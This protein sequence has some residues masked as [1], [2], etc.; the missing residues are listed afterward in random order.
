SWKCSVFIDKNS[1]F[2][3]ICSIQLNFPAPTNYT[4]GSRNGES[5]FCRL[6][7]DGQS[8]SKAFAGCRASGVWLQSHASKSGIIDSSWDA[9]EGYATGS[10][11]GR[12]YHLEYG[13]RYE[14]FVIYYGCRGRDTGWTL[15]WKNLRGHEHGQPTPDPRTRGT[16]GCYG[17]PNV[18]GACIG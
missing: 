2:I 8:N 12:R 14:G 4:K 17:G 6:G 16:C 9:V 10:C 3:I 13:H 1:L 18:G 7:L 15:P 11:A 5:R